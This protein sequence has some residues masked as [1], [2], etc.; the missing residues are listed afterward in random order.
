M[1]GKCLIN[2]SLWLSVCLIASCGGGSSSNDKTTDNKVNQTYEISLDFN[3]EYQTID[4]FGAAL[5]M[6]TTKMLSN[7]EVETLVGTE[8]NQ[9]GLSIVRTI[10]DP[11]SDKWFRAVDNLVAAK[12]TSTELQILATPWSPP[13]YMK[14]NNSTVGGGTLLEAHYADY[15]QHLTDYVNYMSANGVGIDVVS[16]QNEPDWHPD[17][18][19]CDWSGEALAKF[20]AEQADLI[21]TKVLV[22]ESLRFDRAYTDPSLNNAEARENFEYVGGHLYG[23][24]GY[25]TLSEYPLAEQHNK[26]RWMTEWLIHDA[27]GDGAAIWGS[28]NQAVWDETLD[29]VLYQIHQTMQV[30]WNAYIWWW[31]KRFYSFI[32][33]GDSQFG[34]SESQILKRGWAFSHFAKFIRPGAKRIHLEHNLNGV[35]ATAYKNAQN[36]T[37]VLINRGSS[38]K[39]DVDFEMPHLVSMLDAYVTSQTK[40]RSKLAAQ[41]NGKVVL[42]PNLPA[43]SVVTLVIAD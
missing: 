32:G 17:Y 23:I 11:E 34:T 40:N 9:L 7:N 35:Y 1:F 30:N 39:K 29:K 21:P 41:A 14:D 37:L 6:W 12:N 43:R 38:D 33:D 3:T 25:D 2:N 28:D 22:G 16:I 18:E 36:T 42:L 19:S 31:G 15:A 27:D 5:P 20:T 8:E 4:G 26:H 24:D 13:A 10:I